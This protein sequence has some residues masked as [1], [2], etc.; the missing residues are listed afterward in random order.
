MKKNYIFSTLFVC[1]SLGIS[2]LFSQSFSPIG[3]G[4]YTVLSNSV[5][6]DGN[7]V[8]ADGFFQ[9]GSDMF[10]FGKFSGGV[11][12]KVGNWGTTLI[13]GAKKIDNYIYVYG[14]FTQAM[15][16]TN[17]R[18][19]ARYNISTDNWEAL[20]SGISNGY[21]TN[22]VKWGS[23]IIICGSFTDAGGDPNADFIAKWDGNNFS[24]IGNQVVSTN[25][26]TV[27][28]AL[29]VHNNELYVGGNFYPPQGVTNGLAKWDGNNFQTVYGWSEL[30][31]VFEIAFDT[32]G[33]LYI[34]GEFPQKI[35]KY[36]GNAWDYL[37]GFTTTG[38]YSFISKIVFMGNDVIVGGKFQDG[39]G[40]PAIDNIGKYNGS[41]WSDI[42]GGLN[43]RVKDIAISGSEIYIAG[44]FTDAGGNSAADKLVKYGNTTGIENYSLYNDYSIFPNPNRGSFIIQSTKGGVFD[45]IDV[46]GKVINTYTIT[47]TQQTVHENL[48]VGMYFIREKNS[49]SVQ[50]LI[51]E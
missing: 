19:I 49:G 11:W 37:G 17:M 41:S 16:D 30:G 3:P 10:T 26:L 22:L 51:I 45:L 34:G 5:I 50:K 36:D 42:G 39:N 8:Y 47:N 40:N 23:D 43:D 32:N 29:A 46:T 2:N 6:I 24:A 25:S 44:H 7:D 31:G 13:S 38:G 4:N 12:N 14:A 48:P 9:N 35:A 15:N 18:R 28:S 33:N 20:G 1:V 27:V 21:I